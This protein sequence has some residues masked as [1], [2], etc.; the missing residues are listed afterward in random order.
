MARFHVSGAFP[1]RSRSLFVL[2]GSIVDGT[3]AP[4][5]FVHI[6]F[7]L[8]TAMSATIHAVEFIRHADREEVGLCIKYADD[9]EL[10]LWAGLNIGSET[11]EVSDHGA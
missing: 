1:L 6:P 7:N 10:S 8:G 5:M 3:V 4:G 11:V 2:A 9:E